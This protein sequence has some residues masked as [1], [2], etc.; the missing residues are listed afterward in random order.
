M[1]KLLKYKGFS[2]SVICSIEDNVIHGKIECINDLIT[3]EAESMSD[4]KAAFQEAVEDYLET[5]EML[6]KEPDRPMS[7]SFNVR[8]GSQL[9]KTAYLAA[10]EAE[11]SLNDFV[12]SAIE[13]KVSQK[14]EVHL[15]LHTQT[16]KTSKE[17]QVFS[18]SF[19]RRFGKTFKMSPAD[20]TYQKSGMH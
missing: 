10:K 14:R 8:I 1:S 7:G 5:C 19:E 4:I 18:S 12:K 20:E 13:E 11:V 2:G 16:E 3:Y 17:T 9:H 15:H 6:G